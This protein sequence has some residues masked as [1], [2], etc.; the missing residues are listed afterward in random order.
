MQAK[1]SYGQH[2]LVNQG[3]A[4]RIVAAAQAGPGTQVLEIGPGRGVL[5]GR[6]LATG[7]AVTAI[8][9]DPDLEA[10]LRH[11]YPQLHLEIANA[12]LYDFDRLGAGPFTLV[13]NLPY[14]VSKPLLM[15]FY[16][17]RRRF[18]RWVLMMQREVAER[19]LARP[20][21]KEWGPLGILL[22]NV[23]AVERIA[24]LGP[25]SFAPP[26]KVDS[27]VL[28]FDVRPAPLEDLG[29]DA[30]RFADKLFQ[31]F[32]ERRK[33]VRNRFK[34]LGRNPDE[35]LAKFGL[36]GNERV[37]TFDLPLLAAIVRELL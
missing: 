18:P 31:L 19:I 3:A 11:R 28:K 8:E 10:D 22:H 14:N 2:F 9:A 37:E 20:G 23:C 26:P 16:A 36:A 7:A 27:T 1:K 33:T 35:L 25:N 5:T 29:A 4:D 6:L 21:S 30:V 34:A 13:S 32:Q 12:V 15:R 24:D 17:E